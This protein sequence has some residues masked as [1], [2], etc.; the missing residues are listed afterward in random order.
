M[1][2]DVFHMASD[3]NESKPFKMSPVTDLPQP[4]PEIRRVSHAGNGLI[5]TGAA[6]IVL[7][8]LMNFAA[9]WLASMRPPE[10]RR[11]LEAAAGALDRAAAERGRD[12]APLLQTCAVALPTLLIYPLAIFGGLRMKQLRSYRL[13]VTSAIAVM[14]PC[15]CAFLLGLPIGIWALAV[16]SD[17]SIKYGFR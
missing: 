5:V 16:L 7:N 3:D 14:L 15:S 1:L 13:A 12:A 8:C 9:M 4:A 11:D 2:G 10:A 17:P 6:G